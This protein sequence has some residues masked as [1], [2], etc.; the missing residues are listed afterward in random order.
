MRLRSALAE[1]GPGRHVDDDVLGEDGADSPASRSGDQAS[2]CHGR[3]VTGSDGGQRHKRCYEDGVGGA[4]PRCGW[5]AP[6]ASSR[7][8]PIPAWSV[9]LA[10][11]LEQHGVAPHAVE[12]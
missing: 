12:L 9:D 3:A 6:V 5:A 7:S 1:A 4:W 8:A 11:T 2:N 10:A